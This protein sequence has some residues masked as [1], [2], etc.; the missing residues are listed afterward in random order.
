M[1]ARQST[2]EAA[3]RTGYFTARYV[4]AIDDSEQPFA[5]W[6]PP[7][8][9]S[10]RRYPLIVALHGSEADERMIPEECFGLH[11]RCLREEVLLLSPF[12]RGDLSWRWMAEADL[13][14]TINWVKARYR[15]DARRQYLT[16]L[17]LGGY[18][19][20]RLACAYPEQWAAVAPVCGGG[21]VGDLSALK[22]VPV[23]CVHGERDP[24][25]PVA[26]SRRLVAALRRHRYRVRYDELADGGH[27]AWQWLYDPKR[28][29]DSLAGWF[30]RF[31]KRVAPPPVLRPRR[32][33]V[34]KDLFS[35]RL[36]ISYPARTAI[37][38]ETDLLRAEAQRIAQFTFGDWIMRAGRLLLMTDEELTPTE[39]HGAGH[40]MLGR[41]DNHR[42]LKQAER[43]LWARHVKGQMRVAGE[44]YLGK[45]L[46]AATCQ[47]G[48]WDA[49]RLLGIITYQQFQ[50]M[51]GVA[52]RFCGPQV[53]PLAVNLYDTQQNRFIMQSAT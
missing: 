11:E 43:R 51:R 30:L 13:W 53:E 34:F 41:T 27:N 44:T 18:A 17:S 12:G 6:V 45:S 10:R 28:R 47:P 25:V 42:W 21:E 14:D 2:R 39:L 1:K 23:W 24:V 46:I 35:E 52:E 22:S 33:G 20:W 26:E 36:I 48:P 8:Y 37:P 31:R 7:A 50:Q 19:T 40:L 49:E 5:L 38:R 16:G 3:P 32:R 9:S 29:R 4:S 15:I